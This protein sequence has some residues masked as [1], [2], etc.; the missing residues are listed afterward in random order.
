[1]ISIFRSCA[2]CSRLAA[3][4]LVALIAAVA[5]TFT[6]LAVNKRRLSNTKPPV[7]PSVPVKRAQ[8]NASAVGAK[9]FPLDS[10][11]PAGM[12]VT[13]S[14]VS[15]GILTSGDNKIEGVAQ[16]KL[17]VS[18]PTGEKIR[19]LNFVLLGFKGSGELE[20]V[21]GWVR[22]VDFTLAGNTELTLHLNRRVT[23]GD[24]LTLA[25]ERASSAAT[26]YQTDFSELSQA[27]IAN[28]RKV[29]EAPVAVRRAAQSLPDEA[30]ADLC[31]NALRR[32]MYLA[33]SSEKKGDKID[34]TSLLCDQHDRSYTITYGKPKAEK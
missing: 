20:L 10:F 12:P 3:F 6:V 21:K 4:M 13:L 24:K 15:A 25:V 32:A 8:A 18:L 17:Q 22:N 7:S 28:A 33:Q 27:A 5:L 9:E 26:T 11:V 1:M 14:N 23:N 2:N 30:G 19:S 29:G 31:N 16:V 34:I